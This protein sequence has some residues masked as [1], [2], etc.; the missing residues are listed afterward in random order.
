MFYNESDVYYVICFYNLFNCMDVD[1]VIEFGGKVYYYSDGI[2][3]VCFIF[4]N[5]FM[6]VFI[7][8]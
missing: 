3:I 1:F 6:F 7:D 8:R 5:K 4:W 2:I